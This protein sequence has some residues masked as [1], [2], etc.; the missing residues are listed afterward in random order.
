[1]KHVSWSVWTWSAALLPLALAAGPL[2]VVEPQ[3]GATLPT[4]SEGQK[5]YLKM[6]RA[7]RVA[8]FAD[9]VKRAGM[10]AL[11]YYPKPIRLAWEGGARAPPTR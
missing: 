5:A 4:L 7:A 8:F 9:K 3:E 2:K 6:P 1:M 10:V 11:G